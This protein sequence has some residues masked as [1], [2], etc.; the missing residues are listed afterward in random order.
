MK[1]QVTFKSPSLHEAEL[2]F[3]LWACQMVRSLHHR[4][5]V[6]LG[7]LADTLTGCDQGSERRPLTIRG[8][9]LDVR[10][11]RGTKSIY[12]A[13]VWMLGDANGTTGGRVHQEHLLC[14]GAVGAQPPRASKGIVPPVEVTR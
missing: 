3:R 9:L 13:L 1:G 14:L 2:Q 8:S 7:A 12:P 6:S 4:H 5:V 11:T 10:V